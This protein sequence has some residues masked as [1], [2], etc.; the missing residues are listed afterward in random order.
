MAN[1]K[2]LSF[3]IPCYRSEDTITAVVDEIG[4]TVQTREG[5]DYEII[6]VNDGS[7]DGVWNVIE[8]MAENDYHIVGINLSKN[9][10]QHCALMAGY[11]YCSGDYVISLD[12]D[13][14]TP[15]SELYRLIDKLEEGYD[16]VYASYKKEHQN[17]FRIF[18]SKFAK[19]TT[20]YVFGFEDQSNRGSS[21]H[22]MKKFIIDEITRYRF[23]YPYI[24][25]L[26]FRTSN[27]VGYVVVNQR[28]RISG[29]SS[30]TLRTLF[31]LWMNAFTAFSVK[32]L[33]IGTYLGFFLSMLGFFL[34]FV[35]V[36][37][38]LFIDPDMVAGWSSIISLLLVI[39]GMILLIMGLIGEYVGRIYIC[40]NESPQYVVREIYRKCQ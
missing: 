33:R 26:L 2:R 8:K 9:F 35:T 32:P 11:N 10:G 3:V 4:E 19:I 18:G 6:L 34:A 22:V 38:K 24:S 14:Q 36:V 31:S 39:G 21:F 37:R 27:R 15:T 7:P 20:D 28:S 13:G 5:Y 25:G 40:I 17:W 16:A 23:P 12:D 30:Y 1:R 29:E